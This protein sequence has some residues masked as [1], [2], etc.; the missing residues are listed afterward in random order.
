M[1]EPLLIS[2]AAFDRL[3][4]E[5]QGILMSVGAEVEAF[6][7]KS[8]QQDDAAV[9]ALFQGAGG[10]TV[11]LNQDSLRKWQELARATAW[12]DYGERNANCAKLLALAEKTIV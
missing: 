5:Q 7:R 1:L 11:D 3:S 10:R 2:K 6:A 4:K 9:A 12:R 8:A